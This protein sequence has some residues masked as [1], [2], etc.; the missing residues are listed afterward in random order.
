MR[1]IQ[2]V[3]TTQLQEIDMHTLYVFDNESGEMVGEITGENNQECEALFAEMY[4]IN[5]FF[6]SYT[7]WITQLLN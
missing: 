4:D 3:S 6:A 5:D 2:V 7:K 1:S